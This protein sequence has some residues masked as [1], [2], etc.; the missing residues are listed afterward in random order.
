MISDKI[1][2]KVVENNQGHLTSQSSSGTPDPINAYI[3]S[4]LQSKAFLHH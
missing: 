4:P 1:I 3:G 2:N